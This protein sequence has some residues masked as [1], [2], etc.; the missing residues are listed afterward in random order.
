[1]EIGFT[2]DLRADY[3]AAGYGEEDT[4]EFDSLETIE[5]IAGAIAALG[6]RPV[7]IGNVKALSRRLAAG[8]RWPLVFNIAEGLHGV[9]REAQ[10]PALLDAF[11]IPYTFS[12]PLV[13]A[14]TLHKGLAKRVVRDCGVPTAPFAVVEEEA[15]LDGIDL[16]YPLFAKPVAEGTGKGIGAASVIGG[17]EALQAVCGDLLARFR[18][19]VL[20]ERF[21]PGREFTVGI[22][23]TGRAAGSLGVLEVKLRDGAEPDVYSFHNKEHFE[24]LVSY[25]LVDGASARASAA[26]ALAA[27]RALGCRD[28]G[29]VDLRLD[30]N[31]VPNFLEVNPLAGLHPRR[32]DLV[33]LARRVGMRYP[34]LIGRILASA[35]E[36]IARENGSALGPGRATGSTP[37]LA[38]TPPPRTGRRGGLSAQ[39]P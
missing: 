3:L 5:A 16:P 13:L 37:V 6:H 1:M 26:V 23:G 35:Q 20:V 8:E 10:V 27:W 2:Y 4:A 34:E 15:D 39:V 17:P 11:R 18:Q 9:A 30:G 29:R 14:L 32:S 28:G 33:I 24:R 21:L 22:L 31:G 25:R 12:D 38:A 7:R 19:P 36:R